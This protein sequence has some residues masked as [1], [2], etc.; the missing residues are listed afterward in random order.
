MQILAISG[1]LRKQ[2]FN[3][4]LLHEMKQVSPK[5]VIFTIQTLENIP[6]FSKDIEDQGFPQS[7]VDLKT[8]VKEAD[9][10][11]IATPEYNH[12]V[13]GVLKNA[14]DWA[15]RGG[16]SFSDKPVAICGVSDGMYGTARAQLNLRIVMNALNT[17]AMAK[18]FLQLTFAEEKFDQSGNLVDE[19]TK[20]KTT[21]FLQSFISWIN[22]LS[23]R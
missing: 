16:N 22:R 17:H 18:P 11:L 6:L 13:S 20:Q 3:T 2:S 9:G 8:A 19:K 15:S 14:L 12:A 10:I 7:I 4:A 21:E 23:P 5:E 1:S